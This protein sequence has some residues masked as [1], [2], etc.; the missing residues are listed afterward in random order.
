[1][2]TITHPGEPK[3]KARPRFSRKGGFAYTPTATRNYETALRTCAQEVMGK[4]AILDGPLCIKMIAY[5]SIPS[6]WSKKK[7]AEALAG[8]QVFPMRARDQV[9]VTDDNRGPAFN[10]RTAPV[11]DVFDNWCQQ[12]DRREDMATSGRYVSRDIPGYADLDGQGDWTQDPEYSAVWMP[13][14]TADWAPS[15]SAS[16]KAARMSCSASNHSRLLACSM[17]RAC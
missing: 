15:R 8:D 16:S 5:F 12:R 9:V 7:Q 11:A 17:P 2:I 6:S 4:Q 14:V 1:M 10:R 3:G 13:R